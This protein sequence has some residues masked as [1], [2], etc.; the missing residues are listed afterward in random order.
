VRN[1]TYTACM[2]VLTLSGLGCN[3][4]TAFV[5][6]A[7]LKGSQ[8]LLRACNSRGTLPMSWI[9][10]SSVH[11]GYGWLNSFPFRFATASIGGKIGII[12]GMITLPV[13]VGPI[14]AS[15]CNM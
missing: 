4:T 2:K 7:H 8:T 11:F 6:A 5:E 13:V 9:P 3:D 15:P 10:F 12:I 1:P 14:L